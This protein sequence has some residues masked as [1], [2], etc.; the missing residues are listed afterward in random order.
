MAAKNDLRSVRRLARERFGYERLRPGQEEAIRAVLDGR[1]TL[2]VMPT[3]AGKSAI[4]Q[5]A[6]LVL[7]GATVV[8]SPL[9][10]LQRD[11]VESLD[12]V[13]G[14]G[15]AE[16]NSRVGTGERRET[17]EALADDEIEFVFVTP[18]QLAN[19]ETLAPLKDSPPSLF[20]V[21]EAHCV[22][23]W[24]HDFRPEYLRLRSVIDELGRPTVL[25]LT[26]TA[27]PGVR[28]DILGRL[29]VEDAHVVARGFDRP[30][31]HL[32]VERFNDEEAKLAALVDRVASSPKPGIVYAATR[33]RAE[34]VAS[35]LSERDV[36]AEPYH[37]GL[38][39]K[40]RDLVQS[41]FMDDRLDV[42]VATIAFGMGVDKANVRFVF[43]YD[44]SDSVDSYYQELGRAG[45]DGDEAHAHLFFRPEDLALRRFFAGSGQIAIDE[46]ERVARAVHERAELIDARALK[47]ETGLSQTKLAA[48][49]NRLEEAGIVEVVA[50]GEVVPR[51]EHADVTAAAEAL[52]EE[53]ERR[54]AFDRSRVEM[55]RGYAELKG[56][57]REYLLNYF[58]EGYDPPCDFCDNCEAGT[59]PAGSAHE[60][61]PLNTRVRHDSWGEGLVQ[62][63]ESDKMV[64]LF[65][66][67]GYKTLDVDLVGERG[68]LAP[69][70]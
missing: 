34:E 4:Y 8:V 60:P 16:V 54:R 18:E 58:G 48:V 2:A 69:V 15:A 22:S 13:E 70:E 7:P 30:N 21:D 26:A 51:D 44:V 61:F 64:V 43:H 32:A 20:V 3:G 14:G 37:A 38:S 50:T 52:A 11:Q 27:A 53:R 6:G 9:L 10:A 33:R 12:D 1:D 65:D 67:V 41:D 5:L 36:D 42:I 45:R 68:L 49:L 63:Y 28:D 35:A 66:D 57:R 29:G 59:V 56:C 19:G 46:V 31:I 55:I 23:E 17:F 24:G 62:R 25:A 40:Q 39:A 47:D